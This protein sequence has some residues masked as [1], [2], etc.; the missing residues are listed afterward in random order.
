MV[1]IDT[2]TDFGKRLLE[3]LHDEEIV[4]LV[5]VNRHGVPQPSP[6]WFHWEQD[7]VLIFS[8]PNAP[9]VRNIATNPAVAL[10]LNS[11]P[12]GDD[13]AILTGTAEVADDAP[14]VDQVDA[15]VRKYE[16]GLR[17]LG[18]APEEMAASYSA[19]IRVTIEHVRGW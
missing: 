13:I 16:R 3:R 17:S 11:S 10:H 5:T 15:F 4:W 9:K 7:E 1:A 12:H 18:M 19:T 6:V 8:Q 2:S 14:K